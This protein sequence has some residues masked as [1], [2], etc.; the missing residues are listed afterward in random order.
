MG[1]I[2]IAIALNRKVLRPAYVMIRSLVKNNNSHQLYVY[3]LH[4]ELNE[5]DR[6][7][8]QDALLR[9]TKGNQM[10]FIEIN[11]TT[12]SELPHKYWPL[13]IYFRL[14]L[15]E[16]LGGE[17]DRILY[18]DTDVIVNKD[19]SDFYNTDFE[20]NLLV[21]AKDAGF[22]ERVAMDTPEAH[23]WNAFFGKF[24]EDGMIYFCSGV[25][26]MNL[27]GLKQEFPFQK[28]IDTFCL[29]SDKVAFPDQDLLNYMHYKQTKIVD[30]RKFGLLVDKAYEMGMTYEDVCSNVSILHFAGYSKPWLVNLIQY[31]IGKV[32]W[33]YAKDSPFYWELLE[34][35]FYDSMESSIVEDK[36]QELM[37]ENSE[38]KELL[39][40]C[41]TIIRKFSANA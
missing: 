36:L 11:I 2:N 6:L 37:T 40:R 18:L 12:I 4:S 38:L 26:L 8:L 20:D 15:P 27:S 19:I 34:T 41:Q 16:L 10:T 35:V 28:Y 24:V 5:K 21:A 17:I 30:E 22:D 31:D 32:W 39:N 9:D 25:L 1:R 33:E 23:V 3:V 7:L 14:M 29:I 13:E